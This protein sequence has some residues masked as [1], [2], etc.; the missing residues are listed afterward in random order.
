MRLLCERPARFDYKILIAYASK[1]VSFLFLLLMLFTAKYLFG[2]PYIAATLILDDLHQPET[3]M[4]CN[5]LMSCY[6]FSIYTAEMFLMLW[7]YEESCF[8]DNW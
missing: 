3:I 8:G 2:K 5:N 7:E 4:S 6:N 1:V